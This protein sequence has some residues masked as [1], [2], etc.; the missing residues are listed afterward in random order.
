[1]VFLKR[2]KENSALIK[3]YEYRTL[4][5]FNLE[6][7][8]YF[9]RTKAYPLTDI[10]KEMERHKREVGFSVIGDQIAQML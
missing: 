5:P 10:K 6:E 2:T 7:M 3:K 4:W 8:K 9:V 1:M